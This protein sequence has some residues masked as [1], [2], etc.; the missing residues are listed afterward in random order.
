MMDQYEPDDDPHEDDDDD[1]DPHVELLSSPAVWLPS[2][3]PDIPV[4]TST[5]L[6]PESPFQS[7]VHPELT[8][9]TDHNRIGRCQLKSHLVSSFGPHPL[10]DPDHCALL[11]T[12][13]CCVS[14]CL[15]HEMHHPSDYC[16]Y[17]VLIHQ[18]SD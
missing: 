15:P 14:C 17:C 2:V 18:P 1:E 8:H 4:G 11:S 16:H 6:V 10:P 12:D 5:R 9:G 3:N 7:L 13:S